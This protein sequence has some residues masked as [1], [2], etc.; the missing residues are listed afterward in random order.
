VFG[1]RFDS[2]IE[3]LQRITILCSQLT[4]LALT[5]W[6]ALRNPRQP[7]FDQ[8]VYSMWV[9]ATVVLSPLSWIHYMVLLL[10]PLV[11]IAGAAAHHQCSRRTF[12]D[13]VASYLLIAVTIHLRQ[14]LVDA[15]RWTHGVRYL[16]EGSAVALLLGFIAAW[17]FATDRIDAPAAENLSQ[18]AP[19]FVPADHAPAQ[20]VS[21]RSAHS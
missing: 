2:H 1:N 19:A 21:L 9:A 5:V 10:I 11:A 7:V 6:A 13:A 20:V 18:P 16:A 15:D 17:R 3:M 12:R 8:R 14:S 4:I